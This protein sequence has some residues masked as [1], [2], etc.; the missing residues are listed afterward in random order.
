MAS[1]ARRVVKPLGAGAFVTC[2]VAA[3]F[4]PGQLKTAMTP[5]KKMF[6]TVRRGT[7]RG[8]T[9]RTNRYLE[10]VTSVRD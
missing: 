9:H 1:L 10:R 3:A 2:H 6:P 4:S 8:N 7:L 5:I